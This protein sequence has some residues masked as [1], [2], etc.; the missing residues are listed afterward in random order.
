MVKH[1]KSENKRMNPVLWFLFAIIIPLIVLITLI[2]F[3]LSIAGFNVM[4]WA[5]D[6]ANDIPVVSS[7]LKEDEEQPAA[8]GNEKQLQ[9]KI[10]SMDAE[11]EALNQN[12]ED[13]ES[14]IEQLKHDL[15]KLENSSAIKESSP[16]AEEDEPENSPTKTVAGSFKDM[17]K[18][19]AALIIQGLDKDTAVSILKEV[20]NKVRG[21]ILEAMEPK[22]AAALT[23]LFINSED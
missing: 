12:V 18:E 21:S 16:D 4:D 17:D 13:K 7:I 8:H 14:T 2:I 9:A 6:K 11:I 20:S 23:Q 5:K 22:A 15:A 19:Q 1:T 10:T 3:I